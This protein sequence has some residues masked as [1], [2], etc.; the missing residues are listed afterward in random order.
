[1]KRSKIFLLIINIWLCIQ[2]QAQ[3]VVLKIEGKD[4]VK[5]QILQSPKT[6]YESAELCNLAL[7]ND[8]IQLHAKGYL[9]ANVDSFYQAQNKVIAQV[10]LGKQYT[11]LTL[12]HNTIPNALLSNIGF[13]ERQFSK[14][15][16]NAKTLFQVFEKSLTYLENNGYPFAQIYLD[17]VIDNDNKI[18]AS[19]K[20]DKNAF[21]KIDSIDLNDDSPVTLNYIQNY[22]GIKK[23]DVY[24]E[25][26]IRAVS[27]RI[28]ESTI[29]TEQFPWQFK[30]SVSGNTLILRIKGK[31]SNR[32]DILIGLLP[33][34][35]ENKGKLLLTGD[36]KL[37]SVNALSKGESFLFT[38]QN[39]QYKSPRLN[40]QANYPYL[41]NLPFTLSGI[42]D[43]YK[44]DTTFRTV[45]TELGLL[46]ELDA[47]KT[48]K[49]YYNT[50]SNRLITISKD[51]VINTR[52]LPASGDITAT[53]A[54]LEATYTNLDYKFNPHKGLLATIRS[55]VTFRKIVKNS[56][57][58]KII[59][60]QRGSTF[61]YLY[62]EIK[63]KNQSYHVKIS[64]SYFIPIK[65]RIVISTHYNG[66]I[67]FNSEKV[68]K[69]ELFQLGGY[70][71][72]RGVDEGI[73]FAKEFNVIT[74]EP[75]FIL[76][77]NS[78]AFS[79]LDIGL[80]NMPYS[81]VKNERI[82]SLGAGMQFETKG[83]L[84]N[85]SIALAST[86]QT[87]F[88]FKQSKIHFGYIS[89]F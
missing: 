50:T 83:G 2:V 40:L 35:A 48:L 36:V 19:I 31:S 42:F 61:A 75:R 73:L 30:F 55:G 10:H 16:I 64:A 25:S 39:L 8:C 58:E 12:R 67:I 76:S 84:F 79:F 38:W 88:L 57:I 37:A 27:K 47:T 65:K 70:R 60:V 26:K 56:D 3:S 81:I 72:L 28:R 15:P 13:D 45:H 33:N 14:K 43:F 80:L 77:T 5:F 11:W 54:G 62:D 85:L 22:I 89:Y 74:L 4:A 66:G 68:F 86:T 6:T 34:N 41:F 44:K 20:V 24:N 82:T 71:L 52:Q 1:M 78:Y 9:E 59:D 87:S 49:A 17:S 29:I 69:N 51:Q 23:G 46:Y 18:T 21:T 63:L 7:I 53:T 32:A